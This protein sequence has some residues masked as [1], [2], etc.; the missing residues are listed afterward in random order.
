MTQK[1]NN[2]S[3]LIYKSHK[4]FEAER[5]RDCI[6][7]SLRDEFVE[8]KYKLDDLDKLRII[9]D[10][11]D[12]PTNFIKEE[13]SG[14]SSRESQLSETIKTS[15]VLEKILTHYFTKKSLSKCKLYIP[16]PE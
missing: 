10:A 7:I 9:K 11:I 3:D 2:F 5:I 6:L 12:V 14:E 13:R 15:R 1:Y 8:N 16:F 4:I